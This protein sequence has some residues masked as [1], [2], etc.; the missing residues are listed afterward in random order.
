M[1]SLAPLPWGLVRNP[2]SQAPYTCWGITCIYQQPHVIDM[3]FRLWKRRGKGL[4]VLN[5]SIHSNNLDGLTS[6]CVASEEEDKEGKVLSGFPV[7]MGREAEDLQA[8]AIGKSTNSC[9]LSEMD[10]KWHRRALHR[11]LGGSGKASWRRKVMSWSQLKLRASVEGSGKNE[12][13]KNDGHR[14]WSFPLKH[15]PQIHLDYILIHEKI[16]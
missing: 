5:T 13:S 15:E 12:A 11:R 6:R 16:S 10:S 9:H 8:S 2:H 14:K 1:G 4:L 7:A 3:Q